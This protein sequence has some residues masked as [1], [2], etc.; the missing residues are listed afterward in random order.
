MRVFIANRTPPGQPDGLLMQ[1]SQ[2]PVNYSSIG[3]APPPG[4]R[5]GAP[6][7]GRTGVGWGWGGGGGGAVVI[8]HEALVVAEHEFTADPKG[9][10]FTTHLM[11]IMKIIQ[12]N[13]IN[14]MKKI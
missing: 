1:E 4:G 6:E 2:F 3:Q 12:E 7:M 10:T 9:S 13:T 8:R 5:V 11:Q 14:K